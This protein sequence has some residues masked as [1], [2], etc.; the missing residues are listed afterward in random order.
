MLVAWMNLLWRA[1]WSPPEKA[2][3]RPD[4]S[5]LAPSLLV[6]LIE[7]TELAD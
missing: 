4:L 6:L 7:L 2:N 1:R 5:K 3:V